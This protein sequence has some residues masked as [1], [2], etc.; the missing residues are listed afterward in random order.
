MRRRSISR[1]ATT[2]ALRRVSR[3]PLARSNSVAAVRTS[4]RTRVDRVRTRFARVSLRH[5]LGRPRGEVRLWSMARALSSRRDETSLAIRRP[6][7]PRSTRDVAPMVSSRWVRSSIAD[8]PVGREQEF[9]ISSDEL[10]STVSTRTSRPP[11]VTT[12]LGLWDDNGNG[13][14]DQEE[15]EAPT[16]SSTTVC[17]QPR[18][19]DQ[20][21]RDLE[22]RSKGPSNKSSESTHYSTPGLL[23]VEQVERQRRCAR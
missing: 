9:G 8:S 17:R 6:S 23:A 19:L 5:R 4:S 13:F 22:S 7:S 2:S 14:L 12:L 16:C 3:G 18:R 15:L 10:N 11:S 20:L 21:H 1:T